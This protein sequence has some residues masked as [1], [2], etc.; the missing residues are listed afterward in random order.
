MKRILLNSDS[1]PGH[2][3]AK[4]AVTGETDLDKLTPPVTPPAKP[5]AAAPASVVKDEKWLETEISVAEDRLRTLREQKK[6]SPAK[7]APV[8]TEKKKTG[9]ECED[10]D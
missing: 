8:V 1:A 2:P 3:A 5:A 4:T 10:L 9:W 7:P 6:V